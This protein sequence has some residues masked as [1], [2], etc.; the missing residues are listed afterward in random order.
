MAKTLQFYFCLGIAIA[1]MAVQSAQAGTIIKLS[2]GSDADPDVEFDGTSFFTID[3]GDAATTG[4]QNTAVEYLDFLSFLP[5]SGGSYSVSGVAALAPA[6]VLFSSIV[7][8]D[9]TGGSFELFDAANTL[10]LSADLADSVLSGPLGPPATGAL[11]T[12]T[13]ASVT[14]GSLA[15]LIDPGSI[16]VSISMT[17][18]NGG[19]GFS[20]TPDPNDGDELLDP[21]SADI[22]ENIAAESVP[23]PTTAMLAMLAVF[24][25]GFASRRRIC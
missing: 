10:L 6:T 13:F 23:E 25:C 22:T 24:G 2:L 11:F 1:G 4:D 9:F 19:E 8:Q 12:T 18:V 14:G 3:D 16:S 17:N 20:T 7:I 5:A 15:S 21:F